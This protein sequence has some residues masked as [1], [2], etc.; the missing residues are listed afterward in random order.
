MDVNVRKANVDVCYKSQEDFEE[1]LFKH[2]RTPKNKPDSE[3]LSTEEWERRIRL[4]E[5]GKLPGIVHRTFHI[6]TV[7]TRNP[8]K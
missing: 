5:D 4:L 3:E 7:V 2:K 1:A 8:F 6:S